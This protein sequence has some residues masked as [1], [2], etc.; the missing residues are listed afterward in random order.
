MPE[1]ISFIAG[2]KIDKVS[3]KSKRVAQGLH[4]RL[5]IKGLCMIRARPQP[6][7]AFFLGHRGAF[8]I[9]MRTL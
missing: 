8:C 7:R 6:E 3:R 2:A 5:P 9:T 4:S 1:F